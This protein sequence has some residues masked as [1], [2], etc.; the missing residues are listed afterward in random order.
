MS[1]WMDS[2]LPALSTWQASRTAGPISATPNGE[3]R[4]AFQDLIPALIQYVGT[5]PLPDGDHE[6][7]LSYEFLL[8]PALM[9]A[10]LPGIQAVPAPVRPAAPAAGAGAGAVEIYR[11]AVALCAAYKANSN[12][13]KSI[14]IWEVADLLTHLQQ[15]HAGLTTR[16][17]AELFAAAYEQLGTLTEADA[18]ILRNRTKEPLE[19]GMLVSVGIAKRRGL[20]QKLGMMGPTYIP[21]AHD[22]F[23]ESI[24]IFGNA[25]P[26]VKDMIDT[27][28]EET[29]LGA[30][31]SL[32]HLCDTLI[33][34]LSRHPEPVYVNGQLRRAFANAATDRD[35]TPTVAAAVGTKSMAELTAFF[36]AAPVAQYCWLHGYGNHSSAKCRSMVRDGEPR[37]DYTAEHTKATRPIKINGKDGNSAVTPGYRLA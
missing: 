25:H 5:L 23:S 21:S 37:G 13:I 12:A 36:D 8:E 15:G 16:S 29:P 28:C 20:Y 32:D 27:Y 22:S 1:N 18:L 3:Q 4:I 10:W 34:K 6:S 35:D 30:A 11:Q 2:K 31:R 24:V 17:P 14:L 26:K 19:P 7:M 9:A 33:T